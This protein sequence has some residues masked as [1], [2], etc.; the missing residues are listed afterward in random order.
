M[1][2]LDKIDPP[3]STQCRVV[4]LPMRQYIA[5]RRFAV[6]L[7]LLELHGVFGKKNRIIFHVVPVMAKRQQNVALHYIVALATRQRDIAL[8]GVDLFCPDCP[9][10]SS[11]VFIVHN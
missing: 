3:L 1:D 8:I 9:P 5:T 4:A 6:V 2:S 7:P 11:F 10:R